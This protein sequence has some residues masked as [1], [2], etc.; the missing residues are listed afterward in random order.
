MVKSMN[1]LSICDNGDVL[2][3][4][5]IVKVAI[6]IIRIVV[7]I[8]LILSLMITYMNAVKEKDTDLLTKANKSA[9]PKIIAALLVFFIP[10]FVHMIGMIA[11]EESYL[12]CFNTAT[13]SNINAAYE[14]AARAALDRVKETKTQID[15]NIAL[16]K[17]S[18]V[19]DAAVK[20]ELLAELESIEIN[21]S[22]G[23]SLNISTSFERYDDNKY[24][25]LS[26]YYLYIPKDA[27]E[28]MPLVAVFPP[29]SISYTSI[30][31][32][33]EAKDLSNFKA[34]IYIPTI[35]SSARSDW[36][37]NNSTDAVS[38]IK[39]LINE[40]KLDSS[41]ISLTAFSSSGY[42]IYWTANKYRIFSAI[43]PI[44]SG[45][46][47]DTITSNYEDWSYLKT[48]PMKGY[49]EKGGATT[50]NGRN[51]TG[52]GTVDWSA[53]TAMC[54]VVEGLGKCSDCL[55]NCSS[56][57]YLPNVCHGE[58]GDYVFN[59]DKNNNNISDILEW[60]IEQKK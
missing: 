13:V 36:N 53:K 55:S 50:E 42:Y 21:T 23:A 39:D 4:L 7:P 43:A 60:M 34:F 46:S 14:S 3:I 54:S 9:I 52:V 57:T 6:T 15:Y 24:S 45:L 19:R 31:G 28:N 1:V 59:I 5:S 37:T 16:S 12:R 38:K 48:L 33:V 58:I 11:G 49:G 26:G 32:M 18:K 30:K 25:S 51:C 41:R 17:I 20:A 22:L 44:S 35:N 10:T 2:S 47:F 40:Y 27:T 29:N 56:F 8:I